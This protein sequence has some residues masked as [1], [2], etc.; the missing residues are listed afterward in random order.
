MS[1]VYSEKSVCQ[2]KNLQWIFF[3]W[4]LDP[5]KLNETQENM[6]IVQVCNQVKKKKPSTILDASSCQNVK[7]VQELKPMFNFLI[8][9]PKKKQTKLNKKYS[10]RNKEKYEVGTKHP[11]TKHPKTKQSKNTT[12]NAKKRPMQHN[13]QCKKRP[14][15]KRRITNRPKFQNAQSN[16]CNI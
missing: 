2:Q 9:S 13:A 7:I 11:R 16:K 10:G 5:F 1:P 12:P 4:L 6:F 3:C 8:E 14:I 15:T